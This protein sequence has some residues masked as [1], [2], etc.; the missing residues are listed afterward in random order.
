MDRATHERRVCDPD[1]YRPAFCPNCGET[2]LHVHDYRRRALRA[3]PGEPVATIVRHACVGCT[4]IWQTLPAFIARHLWRSWRVVERTLSQAGPVLA[5]PEMRRWPLVSERTRRRWRTRWLR[6]AR[7]L[8]QVLATCG[9]T[10][11]SALAGALAPEATCAD[12]VT[13]YAGARATPAGQQ[14][15][16]LAALLYRLQPKVRLM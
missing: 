16:S 1:G 2:T 4:A 11:W 13:A 6:P 7:F 15:L 5:V 12:L 14:L 9:E 3:E 8:I 10:A